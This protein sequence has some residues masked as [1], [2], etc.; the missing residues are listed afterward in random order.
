MSHNYFLLSVF[1]LF[2]ICSCTKPEAEEIVTHVHN[3]TIKVNVNMQQTDLNGQFTYTPIGGVTVDLYETEYDRTNVQNLLFTR[4]TSSDGLAAFYDLK[5]EYYYIRAYHPTYG[6]K[7]DETSTPDGSVS[8][9]A[10]D[11]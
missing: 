6:E 1:I 2:S 7:L 10:I 3:A 11:F 5:K 8:F 9:V 4:K